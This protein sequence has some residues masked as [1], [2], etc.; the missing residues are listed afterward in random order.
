MQRGT[1]YS[2]HFLPFFT[3][4]S[5][6]SL[7]FPPKHLSP[8]N[9]HN[10]H[11]NPF[12]TILSP[13][14]PCLPLQRATCS[15]VN[16]SPIGTMSWERLEH[17]HNGLFGGHS[18]AMQW[19]PS[20]NVWLDGGEGW[21]SSKGSYKYTHTCMHTHAHTCIHT[22]THTHTHSHTQNATMGD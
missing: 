21:A 1:L 7:L 10:F 3:L 2:L 9:N 20:S 15:C 16:F 13:C 19:L 6:P 8:L 12:H 11:F 5:S 18:S 17:N 14:P 4:P 22:H